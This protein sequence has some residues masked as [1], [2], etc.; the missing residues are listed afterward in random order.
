MAFCKA[1]CLGDKFLILNKVLEKRWAR[2]NQQSRIF[3]W[4][5]PKDPWSHKSATWEGSSKKVSSWRSKV[6]YWAK[7]QCVRFFS[8]R[9][10]NLQN[11]NAKLLWETLQSNDFSS[12]PKRTQSQGVRAKYL[13]WLL[14]AH[15][16]VCSNV[17]QKKGPQNKIYRSQ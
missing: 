9:T 7:N 14:W 11:K 1:R 4:P 17:K 10:K 6:W 15:R 5:V 12:R 3:P 2:T 13:I 8:T 16:K